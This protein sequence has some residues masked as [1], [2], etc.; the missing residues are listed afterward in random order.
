MWT[1][2]LISPVIVTSIK[3]SKV[4]FLCFTLYI[5]FSDFRMTFF[6]GDGPPQNIVKMRN[7]SA[8]QKR[9][10]YSYWPSA[11]EKPKSGFLWSAYYIP[12]ARI[13][14]LILRKMSTGSVKYS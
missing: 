4:V 1:K 6:N 11:P 2:R 10:N 8:S 12:D 9:I 3:R 5:Q 13:E 14:Y 7:K